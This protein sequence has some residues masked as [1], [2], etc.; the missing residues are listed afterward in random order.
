MS[1]PAAIWR[2]IWRTPLLVLHLLAGIMVAALLRPGRDGAV[3]CMPLMLWSR[4]L[5]RVLGVR[6]RVTGT[7]HAGATL[8]VANHISWLDIFCIAA[9]CPT[10]FLAKRE[11]AGWPLVGWLSR[12]AGTAFIRRG[13]DNGAGE[14]AEQLTW[15][16]RNRGRVLVFPEGTSTDGRSVRRFF[17]RLFQAALLARCPVQAIALRY[18]DASGTGLHARVP[19]IDDAALL[20]HLW[21]LLGERRIVVELQFCPPL[22]VA[23]RSRNELAEQARAQ[24]SAVLAGKPGGEWSVARL[25]DSR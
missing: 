17:A 12:R 23:G 4:V 13:G 6:I 7:P 20:P 22:A 15:R 9:V 14:A 1:G 5:C 8:F 11:V 24:I 18:P 16:L 10:H 2:R 25:Q 19:F 21:A 3:S